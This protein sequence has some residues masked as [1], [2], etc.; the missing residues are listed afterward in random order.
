MSVP[1]LNAD[2]KS[3]LVFC[4]TWYEP[5]S[6]IRLRFNQTLPLLEI[7]PTDG[8]IQVEWWAAFAAGYHLESATNLLSPR[9]WNPIPFPPVAL[10]DRRHVADWSDATVKF[11]RLRKD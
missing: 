3:D 7:R 11:Y 9:E 10:G 5:S 2:G 6:S 1:D 8:H 4:G